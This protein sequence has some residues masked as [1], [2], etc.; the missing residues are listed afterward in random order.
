MELLRERKRRMDKN[1]SPSISGEANALKIQL[2]HNAAEKGG[3][4]I[5]RR[6]RE[7]IDPKAAAKLYADA[8]IIASKGVSEIAQELLE[9]GTP[10]HLAT[11]QAYEIY[12]GASKLSH[13]GRALEHAEGCLNPEA[14]YSAPTDEFVNN[15]TE[16]VE[17]V[18]DD[19]VLRMFG[20]VLAGEMEHSGSFSKKTLSIL[21]DMSREDAESFQ[22]LCRHC[23]GGNYVDENGE[24]KYFY[25]RPFLIP[26]ENGSSYNCEQLSLEEVRNFEML[27][28]ILPEM[29]DV[30][31]IQPG[32]GQLIVINGETYEAKNPHAEYV[33]MHLGTY[34]FSK[35]GAELATLC[36]LGGAPELLKLVHN[37]AKSQGLVF[38]KIDLSDPSFV[39]HYTHAPIDLSV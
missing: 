25:S 21:K 26:N 33:K 2:T 11:A 7:A 5:I 34:L 9:L 20:Q 8:A 6:I 12:R 39:C 27:G 38:R 15:F 36:E 17:N 28:L 35:W 10:A 24:T 29:Y 23:I 19:D 32:V 22:K 18:S 1:F 16:A 13:L 31:S 37:V 14:T 4:G 30:F 3:R